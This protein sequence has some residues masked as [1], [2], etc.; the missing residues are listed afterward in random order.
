MFKLKKKGVAPDA[1]AA[2]ALIA[3]IG[4]LIVLYILFIPP[5]ERE[6]ILLDEEELAEKEAEEI[7]KI[8][9]SE[10]PQRLFPAE[11]REFEQYFSAIN[12][13]VG[14]EGMELKKADSLYVFRTLFTKRKINISFNVVDLPNIKDA[15]LN[16]YVEE[17]KGRLIVNLNGREVFNKKIKKGNIDPI[18]LKGKLLEGENS[19][20][21]E[22]SSPGLLFL[23]RNRYSL[24]DILVTADVLRRDTQE[25]TL[26]FI[27][28]SAEKD[29]M[30]KV[31]LR[32][33]PEC[34]EE[35][36]GP[37]TISINDD[38]LYS[39]V[40]ADCNI[41]ARPIEFL[42]DKLLVGE[43]TLKFST[44]K[45]WYLIDNIKLSSELKEVIIPVYYFEIEEED[46]EYVID[47]DANVTLYMKFIDDIT[48]KVADITV[49]NHL[50]RLDQEEIEF[51]ET[52]NKLVEE[53][54]NAIKIE[55]EEVLDIVELKVLLES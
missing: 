2:A 6:K 8:L 18:D 47:D 30:R 55:P 4:F 3:I 31:K 25:S 32:Y 44:T 24:D 50:M 22:V 49:N 53:G 1:S 54:N 29:N 51:N 48:R 40:P 14:E 9:L 36:I 42:P 27:V 21:F 10:S 15:L 45:G 13:Y 19:L 39:A 7:S 52:I 12:I 17:G 41:L 28:D 20:E 43:N 11:K 38:Q 33:L 34:V 35:R 5:E 37:L 46:Y 16:F 26:S 23:R